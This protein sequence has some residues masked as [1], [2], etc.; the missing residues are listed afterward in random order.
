LE[1]LSQETQFLLDHDLFDEETFGPKVDEIE[2]TII[3]HYYEYPKE[4]LPPLIW[5]SVFRAIVPVQP[6][7]LLAILRLLGRG[8]M[9]IEPA[10]RPA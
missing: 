2:K 4:Q 5:E 7:R 1:T 3:P 6:V 10:G 8:S 9:P